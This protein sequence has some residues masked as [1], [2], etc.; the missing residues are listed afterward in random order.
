VLEELLS[1]RMLTELPRVLGPL[2]GFRLAIDVPALTQ[3]L[4][5]LIRDGTLTASPVETASVV[6]LRRAACSVLFSL[7]MLCIF[8][9]LFF[10]GV[11]HGPHVSAARPQFCE[12]RLFP[13]RR[14][15]ARKSTFLRRDCF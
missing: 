14:T 15:D 4:G 10:Q 1:R 12:E 2:E 7:C 3:A 5:D 8:L 9:I 6:P 13:D 11:L